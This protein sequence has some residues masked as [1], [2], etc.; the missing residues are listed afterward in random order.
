MVSNLHEAQSP[1]ESPDVYVMRVALEKA[2]AVAALVRDRGL[3]SRSVL[4][5]DTEVVLDGEV[6]GKPRDREHG[7]AML[8]RLQGRAHEV[9]TA[10]ALVHEAGEH[11]A[12]SRSRVTFAPITDAEIQAYWETGESADKAGAYAIQGRAA[13][14]IE[15][16]DGSYTGVMGLPLLD[17]TRLFKQA[18]LTMP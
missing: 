7:V 3:P 8:H 6:L 18:G 14:F 15:R 9:L 13:A 11:S 16:L 5:A 4:G 2:R 12:L 1:G 17:V 10:V